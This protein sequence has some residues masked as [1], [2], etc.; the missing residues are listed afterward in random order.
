MNENHKVKKMITLGSFCYKG[1]DIGGP[2]HG[3]MLYY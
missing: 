1:K 3:C 2:K